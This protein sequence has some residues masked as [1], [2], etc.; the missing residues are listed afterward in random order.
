MYIIQSQTSISSISLAVISIMH[1][2]N[3]LI[4]NVVI[5]YSNMYVF[6]RR[7][8]DIKRQYKGR[9]RRNQIQ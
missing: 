9:E 4:I 8:D 7:Y 5:V 3:D 2:G 1:I 6:N